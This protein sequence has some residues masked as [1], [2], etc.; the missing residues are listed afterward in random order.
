MADTRLAGRTALVTG[1]GKR[2]GRATALALA[3][4]GADVVAHFFHSAAEAEATAEEIRHKGRRAWAVGADL[5]DPEAAGALFARAAAAADRP[6]DILVNSASIF[7][8]GRLM[9]FAPE[10]LAVNLQVNALSPLALCRAMAAQKAPGD[11]VNFLDTRILD[12]DRA[13][14]PYHLSKQ[15]LL[16]FT[17]MLALELAPAV[18]VNAVA[19]G[20]I[21]PPSGKDEEYLIRQHDTN[22]LSRHGSA[23]DVTDAVL[24]LI[25]N[26]F[27]T[28]QVIFVDGGRHMKGGAYGM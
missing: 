3:E 7:P 11:I 8:R 14:V 10:D 5:A 23:D 1:A 4:A 17:R 6:I 9:A 27:I 20:L 25:G 2:L 13:H 12:Y 26:S 16:G 22:P 18:K 24:M 21:L 15:M 19:P 28:G